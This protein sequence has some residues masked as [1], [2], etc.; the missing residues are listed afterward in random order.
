MEVAAGGKAGPCFS[1]PRP[2]RPVPGRRAAWRRCWPPPRAPRAGQTGL[3]PASVLQQPGRL[4]ERD[5]GG[6]PS[7][8]AARPGDRDAPAAPSSA[9]RGARPCPALR[10]VIPGPAQGDR[11]EHGVDDLAPV[12]GEPGL[13]AV[14]CREHRHRGLP[15][16]AAS[17]AVPALLGPEPSVQPGLGAPP[18]PPA[19]RHRRSPGPWPPLLDS[20]PISAAFS[21]WRGHRRALFSPSVPGRRDRCRAAVTPASADLC[22]VGPP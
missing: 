9:S 11:A 1:G 12:G 10:A 13:V 8:I 19:A 22:L 21:S 20:R 17:S 5:G 16:S 6:G 14:S 4:P 3:N 7:F 15:R 18:P 2:A